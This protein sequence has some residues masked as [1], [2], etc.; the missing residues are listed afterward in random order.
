M[1]SPKEFWR[2]LLVILLVLALGAFWSTADPSG[3]QETMAK[4]GFE[5]QSAAAPSAAA[6]E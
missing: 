2:G 6:S 3:L 5:R 4:I 1:K